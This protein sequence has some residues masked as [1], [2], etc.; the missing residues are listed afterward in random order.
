MVLVMVG[1]CV[2]HG[3]IVCWSRCWSWYD[4]VL[5]MV[6]V[7]VG[8]CVGHG[9]IVCWSWYD[10]VLVMVLVM[11]GLCVGHGTIVCWS[12]YNCVL[13]MVGLCV[14]HGRIVCWSVGGADDQ[15]QRAGG[16]GEGVGGPAVRRHR[17]APHVRPAHL[18]HAQGR[19]GR[20]STQGRQRGKT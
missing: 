7:M 8:L 3:R 20:R 2:G 6:L 13:V 1:L 11:V 4:C 10:C 18:A 19:Q 16:G 17:G 5:V 9:R 15:V 14:G 12:W